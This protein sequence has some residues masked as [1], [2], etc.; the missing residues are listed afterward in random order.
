MHIIVPITHAFTIYM[1][2]SFYY[3][4]SFSTLISCEITIRTATKQICNAMK[5]VSKTLKYIAYALFRHFVNGSQST[6]RMKIKA[7]YPCLNLLGRKLA[8]RRTGLISVIATPVLKPWLPVQIYTSFS[9][10]RKH[11]L[12]S[13]KHFITCCSSAF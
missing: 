9:I 3:V 5:S 6:C 10:Y 8:E 2:Y 13:K 7:L 4:L 12:S 1:Y 11:N